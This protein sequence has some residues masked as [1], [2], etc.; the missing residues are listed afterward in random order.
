MNFTGCTEWYNIMR[1]ELD[2]D[3]E[4]GTLFAILHDIPFASDLSDDFARVDDA[5]YERMT[6]GCYFTTPPS[7][8]EVLY[9]F[10]NRMTLVTATDRTARYYFQVILES[11]LLS[12]YTDKFIKTFGIA[13]EEIRDRISDLLDRNYAPDGAGG[14]F[15]IDHDIPIVQ[16]QLV[17]DMRELGMWWQAQ[18]WMQINEE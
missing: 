2:P 6:A 3:K 16:D 4:Y 15:R 1:S 9:A 13:Q 5:W 8:L 14:W 10:V 11:S 17:T 12:H 7:V 18:A